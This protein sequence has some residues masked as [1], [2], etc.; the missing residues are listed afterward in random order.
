[1]LTIERLVVLVYKYRD[2]SWFL[3]LRSDQNC[4][5]GLPRGDL[6]A[7]HA[8]SWV[9]RITRQDRDV[10][11]LSGIQSDLL[12]IQGRLRYSSPANA[13]ANIA[14]RRYT[15]D[16]LTLFT[17]NRSHAALCHDGH[18][19]G[20][21]VR[22]KDSGRPIGSLRAARRRGVRLATGVDKEG[23]VFFDDPTVVGDGSGVVDPVYNRHL[24]VASRREDDR[25]RR[26]GA[27]RGSLRVLGC[28]G[29]VVRTRGS[30]SHCK[31]PVR[32]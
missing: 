12:G 31:A 5:A 13:I 25:S 28:E 22:A 9:D 19:A 11:M 7:A 1:M 16:G 26:R 24:Q 10:V 6:R 2:F 27:H 18:V 32:V 20:V 15:E 17:G 3:V 29:Q 21:E 14:Y 4:N 8:M 30:T 23:A